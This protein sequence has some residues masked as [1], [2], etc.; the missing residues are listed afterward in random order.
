MLRE[1]SQKSSQ[2]NLRGEMV[3]KARP[4]GVGLLLCVGAGLLSAVLN[5]GYSAA[6][7]LVATALRLGYSSFAG[8]N[9]IWLLCWL[10][11]RSPIFV[12][13]A[14]LLIRNG[15]WKKFAVPNSA[16]LY[17]LAVLMGV[18]WGG[19]IFLYGFASP[20]IGRLGPSIGWPIK[21]ISGL[22]AANVAGYLIGEW[23]LTH[24]KEQRWMLA[25]AGGPACRDCYIR[26]GG[27]AGLS[28]PASWRGVPE[29]Q[30]TGTPPAR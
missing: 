20:K 2:E 3:G 27:H 29:F 13:A 17:C 1:K 4:M 7:P 10:A 14:Y 22:I 26:V 11:D 16:P 9:V 21:L 25:G 23:K 28:S 6:Q 18:L 8:S 24:P 5:I 19:E 15:S 12:F 30:R